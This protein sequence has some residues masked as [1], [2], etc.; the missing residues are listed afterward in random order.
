MWAPPAFLLL[1]EKPM[2]QPPAPPLAHTHRP[3]VPSSPGNGV[4]LPPL[5]TAHSPLHFPSPPN[6]M[7][8]TDAAITGRPIPFPVQ[9]PRSP[10]DP[11]KG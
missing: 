8:G 5:F 10:S 1:L 6:R 9:L 11:I 4:A 2:A 3:G 7:A